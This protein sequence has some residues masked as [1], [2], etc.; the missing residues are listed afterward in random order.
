M[1]LTHIDREA[2]ANANP[3][4]STVTKP[5]LMRVCGRMKSIDESTG[6]SAGVSQVLKGQRQ[7]ARTPYT[8]AETTAHAVK[9]IK[10]GDQ[11]ET[12]A[13]RRSGRRHSRSIKA[14]G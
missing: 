14:V 9:I 12:E 5:A 3:R 10:P 2:E 13:R 7:E 1:Y 11:Q 6:K 4:G 8:Q